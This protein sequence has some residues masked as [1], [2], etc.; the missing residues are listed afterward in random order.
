MGSCKTCMGFFQVLANIER[1]KC[2]YHDTLSSNTLFS[3]YSFI[4]S[5]YISQHAHFFFINTMR[6]FVTEFFSESYFA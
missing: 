2:G 6:E 3:E 5:L 4:H 1:T